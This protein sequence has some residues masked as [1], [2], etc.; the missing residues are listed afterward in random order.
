VVSYLSEVDPDT[1]TLARERYG[2]LT[3]WQGDPALYG[4]AAVTGRFSGCEKPVIAMLSDLLAK[5][6]ELAQ[7]AGDGDRF[8]DAARNAAVIAGAEQYYRVMYY[9]SRESWN[10]R[11][12][13]MFETLRAVLDHRGPDARAIVWAHNSHVGDAAATEMGARG[14]INIGHLCRQHFGDDAYIVG[15]GTHTGTVAAAHSW[16]EPMQVMKVRPSH[17]SSYERLF[18]DSGVPALLLHLRHPSREAIREELSKPRLERAIGVV[19]RPETELASHYFHAVLPIQ[20]DE[21][22]WFDETRA[23]TPLATVETH[24]DLPE[25]YPFG[26]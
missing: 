15:F 20:L 17:A 13:H 4:R 9:G 16:D 3:P 19:Y 5:R 11:D 26:L 18:H 25:T 8:F 10:L 1:A 23:V 24:G 6:V 21:Y 12:T 14:E 22:C 2:C 7:R